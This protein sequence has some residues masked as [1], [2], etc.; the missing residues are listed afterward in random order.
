MAAGGVRLL[1]QLERQFPTEKAGQFWQRI[2][3]Q[4]VSNYK[5]MGKEEQKA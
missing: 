4:A 5:S 3:P 2:Y 1:K